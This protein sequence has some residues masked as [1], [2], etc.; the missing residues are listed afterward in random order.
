MTLGVFTGKG[1][2][3]R[4]GEK[5]GE[6]QN[7]CYSSSN[8]F[9]CAK[10]PTSQRSPEIVRGTGKRGSE[11]SRH[12]L[13]S[14]FIVAKKDVRGYGRVEGD[15]KRKKATGTARTEGQEM[16]LGIL[17]NCLASGRP[18]RFQERIKEA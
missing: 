15:E 12:W 18:G 7:K 3:G 6:V 8:T 17:R 13:A 1:E 9:S 16:T 5:G 14:E 11:G 4:W 2:G 10:I